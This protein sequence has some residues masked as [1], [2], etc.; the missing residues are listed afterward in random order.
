MKPG[1]SAY[2][3]LWRSSTNRTY[4]DYLD[5][6]HV[7]PYHLSYI[8][9]IMQVTSLFPN[10]VQRLKLRSGGL[11]NLTYFETFVYNSW[12]LLELPISLFPFLINLPYNIR[13]YIGIP[14]IGYSSNN[15]KYL[16]SV[17]TT[18]LSLQLT[19]IVAPAGI[20]NI[21]MSSYSSLLHLAISSVKYE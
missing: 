11:T 10:Q 14:Q 17:L 13:D 1:I 9:R 4:F 6:N 3:R 5:N 19:Q 7:S 20:S 15:P 16:I 2:Q 21:P 8:L 12:G 18:S